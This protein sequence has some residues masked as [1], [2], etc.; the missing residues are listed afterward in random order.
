MFKIT[1]KIINYIHNY[2]FNTKHLHPIYKC[3]MLYWISTE[4]IKILKFN[5][6][7]L[8]HTK[9]LIFFW[10]YALAIIMCC[11]LWVWDCQ[12]KKKWVQP[13][14]FHPSRWPKGKAVTILEDVDS[15]L[16]PASPIFQNGSRL[17][18]LNHSSTF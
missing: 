10:I 7:Q 11:G 8:F 15:I 17:D 3:I 14:N 18:L 6:F 12:F 9:C 4:F 1:Y 5:N 16:C 13:F 2:F